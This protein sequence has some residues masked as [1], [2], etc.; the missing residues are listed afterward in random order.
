MNKG[1]IVKT[2]CFPVHLAP[3]IE[4]LSAQRILSKTISDLLWETYGDE[5]LDYETAVINQMK[6][7]IDR[8]NKAVEIKEAEILIKTKGQVFKNKLQF[9]ETWLS[10]NALIYRTLKDVK[11][12]GGQLY[13][14]DKNR[15]I[16][17]QVKDMI[18]KSGG[19]EEAIVFIESVKNER[20]NLLAEIKNPGS[21]N[22]NNNNNIY[23]L[24]NYN[25]R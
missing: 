3:I 13:I 5:D 6:T 21:Y 15:E 25:N 19:L 23:Y 17:E 1:R 18:E 4:K 12:K 2:L 16:I 10:D 9:I 20:E 14:T 24:I 22:N 8:L 11:R 7:E